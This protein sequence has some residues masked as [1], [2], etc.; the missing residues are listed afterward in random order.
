MAQTMSPSTLP[1]FAA[2]TTTNNLQQPTTMA[3]NDAS[4]S[5]SARSNNSNDRSKRKVLTLIITAACAFLLG[6]QTKTLELY[7]SDPLVDYNYPFVAD[8]P[9]SSGDSSSSIEASN[10]FIG[11]QH[12]LANEDEADYIIRRSYMN[13]YA[14]ILPCH[15]ATT[16]K[17][18]LVQTL[19]HF[20]PSTE[21]A[22]RALPPVPWWFRT[23]L[24]DAVANGK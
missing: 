7:T 23:L 20:N 3:T 24:R 6:R 13:S 18:C 8:I 2:T 19:N 10:T 21:G 16:E 9:E 17:N 12:R 4:Y 22:R 11:A 14:H 1:S 5:G 15:N